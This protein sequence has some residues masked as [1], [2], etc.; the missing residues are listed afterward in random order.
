MSIFNDSNFIAEGGEAIIYDMGNKVAKI[1]KKHI[2]L[3]EKEAKIKAFKSKNLPKNVIKPLDLIVENG[4]FVG[5]YMDKVKGEELKI[6]SNKKYIKS[7][8]ISKLNILTLLKNIKDTLKVIHSQGIVIGD[9]NDSNILFDLNFTP[10]FI[11]VDSWALDSFECDVCMD[12]FKDPNLISNKFTKETD[13]FALSIIIFKSLTRLHPFSG[14]TT[15]DMNLTDR[16]NNRISVI[17]NDKVTIPKIADN[18]KLIAPSILD[19]LKQIFSSNHREIIDVQLDDFIK[20]NSY[21]KVCG[22][23]FYSKFNSCPICDDNAKVIVNPVIMKNKD[24]SVIPLELLFKKDDISVI[25]NENLYVDINGYIDFKGNKIN[26]KPNRKV[27]NIGSMLIE[28]YKD[29]FDNITKK[30][31]TD[32]KVIGNTIFYIAKNNELRV[33]NNYGKFQTE[34]VITK[35]ANNS[36][37]NIASDSEF[38]ILNIYSNFK[39]VNI[40]GYNYEISNTDKVINYTIQH[41][42]ITNHW[43]VIYEN[44]KGEFRTFI[45]DNNKLLYNSDNLKYIGSLSNLCFDNNILFKPSDKKIVAFRY[46]KNIIKEFDCEIVSEDSSLSRKEGKFII[47]NEKEIY[48][49]G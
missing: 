45:F 13:Y 41:D 38:C 43:L 14:T 27:Y 2:N 4:K 29:S 10:Y 24:S 39:I 17:D 49:F 42:N 5:Y 47:V 44:D 9:F 3:K 31:N 6:L 8:N 30:Y 37:Y 36:Y 34:K 48:K 33:I 35:V 1:Y 12:S 20:N 15:P 21:C 32:I 11:D 28:D 19:K 18:Y 25:L 22:N 16:I 46:D 40:N 7:N 26:N 23:I